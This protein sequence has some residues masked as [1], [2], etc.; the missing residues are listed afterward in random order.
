MYI[1]SA[2]FNF[3]PCAISTGLEDGAKTVFSGVYV[4]LIPDLPLT[5]WCCFKSITGIFL[6]II[7]VR[8][9]KYKKILKKIQGGEGSQ[10]V[11]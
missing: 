7:I 11:F 5:A 6:I 4:S 9:Y 1:S 8:I 3:R 10:C 2:P